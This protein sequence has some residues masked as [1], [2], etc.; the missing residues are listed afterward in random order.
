MKTKI[1]KLPKVGVAFICVLIA[2][3]YMAATYAVAWIYKG[4]V[5][6]DLPGQYTTDM[7]KE[8][9]DAIV[10][11]GVL[12]L[13]GYGYVLKQK[14][15]GLLRGLYVSA[16]LSGYL[17]AG[18]TTNI[19]EYSANP[20][21]E[22]NSMGEIVIFT[23]TMLFIGVAE[24]VLMRGCILN[25]LLERFS[26]TSRGIWGAVLI[27]SG[28]FGALHMMN[29]FAGVKPEAA[30]WQSVNAF[31]IGLVFSAI[32][33]RCKNLWFSII[34]HA[35]YDFTALMV[36][37]IWGIGTQ[38]DQINSASGVNWVMCL[39]LTAVTII[40]LK[41]KKSTRSNVVVSVLMGILSILLSVIGAFW[42]FG[43]IGVLA[44]LTSKAEGQPMRKAAKCGMILSAIG[45]LLG[46][47]C[48]IG[49]LIL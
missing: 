1:L 32:Y 34:L 48:T 3:M 26:Q 10:S 17:I 20:P 46:I 2:A 8:G 43:V 9:L 30:F 41:K 27:E 25:L 39:L 5:R 14:G 4:I 22:V 23:V 24:E 38:V 7:I 28:I 16:F 45:A 15:V 18:M 49:K 6:V 35:A 37:G 21:G 33:I 11:I 42:I 47:V 12:Y 19:I 40:L 29:V 44:A 13:V 36:S 31:L